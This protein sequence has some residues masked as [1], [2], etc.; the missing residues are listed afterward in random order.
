MLKK[1][2]IP[3]L[4]YA[5]LA[6]AIL[7]PLLRMGYIFAIDM[8]FTPRMDF[9]IQY[10][11]LWESINTRLP[12]NLLIQLI[13]DLIP[14][15]IVQKILLLG[16]FFLAGVGAHRLLPGGGVGSYFA[17]IF[18]MV[19]PFTYIRFVSGQWP[20]LLAYA[21]IPFAVKA[22][23]DMLERGGKRD[24]LKLTVLTTMVGI[25]FVHALL[26]LFFVFLAILVIRVIRE[27]KR[28][29]EL[30]GMGRSVTISAAVFLALNIYWLVPALL[31]EDSTLQGIGRGDMFFFSPN[32]NNMFDLVS[33]HGFWNLGY[34]YASDYLPF[35]P[36][37]FMFILFLGF[38]GLLCR[39]GER[40]VG[41]LRA[42]LA[43]AGLLGFVLAMGVAFEITRAPFEWLFENVGFFRGFRDT[44]KFVALLCLAYAYLG[45][46]GI[47][48]IYTILMQK[49]KAI[50]SVT[51]SVFLAL[52]LLVPLVYTFPLFGTWGQL[53]VTDYP[54]EWYEV[55]EYLNQDKD[56]FNVL[57]LP[58]HL[59]MDF[60]WLPN[61]NQRLGNP[62]WQF[63]DKPI[64]SGDN[65]EAAGQY[66][67]ST[68]PVS[69]Y[70]EFLL[71]HAHEIDNLGELLAPLNVKYIIL[72]HEADYRNYDFVL[73]QSDMI[74]AYQKG[75]ITLIKNNHPVAKAYAVN[76]T[77]YIDNLEEYLEISREQDVTE[78]LYLFGD[79]SKDSGGVDGVQILD[80]IAKSPV[81]YQVGDT[82]NK[83]TI[84]ILPQRQSTDNWEYNG[85][86]AVRNLGVMPAFNSVASGGEILYS[87][88]HRIYLPSYLVSATA[89][90]LIA[91][92]WL[93]RKQ[94]SLSKQ[95]L[96]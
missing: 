62:A 71:R 9:S 55:N 37:L 29:I 25:M 72:T 36:I 91:A 3:Y 23:M 42:S 50:R 24:I 92:W 64:I 75:T 15:W 19:N 95:Q 57:F 96:S 51:T 70:V 87:K 13:D 22:F 18:Y 76:S 66:S 73:D 85:Q 1:N 49:Q 4:V 30:L 82:V 31:A 21:L 86:Q 84:F 83:Y 80:H 38:Y 8:L 90:L 34:L 94:S 41:L 89:W 47:E 43:I 27:R 40:N 12:L 61:T 26:M 48:G 63:F 11:G 52:A 81:R 88:F 68:N 74:T 14:I 39:L 93:Y 79:S 10:Y 69:G 78:H 54:E 28:S 5:L 65:I 58:W 77:I 20:F 59:Y 60:S 45:G 7:G 2:W 56:D 6:L 46:L 44:H 67:S 17:G 32:V 53:K 33:L 35:W 16:A